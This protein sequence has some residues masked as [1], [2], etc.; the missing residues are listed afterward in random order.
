MNGQTVK[1]GATAGTSEL[2][3]VLAVWDF[4]L[5]KKKALFCHNIHLPVQEPR[6]GKTG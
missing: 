1:R 3:R 6:P 5:E 2:G 4:V